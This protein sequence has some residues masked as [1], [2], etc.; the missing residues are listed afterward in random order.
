MQAR[1]RV[2][3]VATDGARELLL[4]ALFDER[5]MLA[6]QV[7]G[8]RERLEAV[9]NRLDPAGAAKR[10][11][12]KVAREIVANGIA[13][14]PDVLPVEQCDDYRARLE[15]ELAR[16]PD[17]WPHEDDRV[18]QKV[19]GS[20]YRDLD[21]YA[22]MAACPRIVVNRRMNPHGDWGMLDVF[23]VD[24][25]VPELGELAGQPHLL[26]TF[27]H[28]AGA[29]VILESVHLYLNDSVTQTRGL[30]ADSYS[31]EFKAFWYLTDVP[32]PSFGPHIYVRGSHR[33]GWQRFV[34]QRLSEERGIAPTD[35]FV[36]D[37]EQLQVVL[38]RRGSLVLSDQ[39]GAHRGMPQVQGRRRLVLVACYTRASTA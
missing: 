22:A 12:S 37:P 30:H 31:P 7:E 15:A 14:V 35:V 13:V 11:G 24:R 1:D 34:N 29:S 28:V 38:G 3:T 39:R 21:D 32:D 2:G 20:G 10:T 27:S 23:H 17:R 6:S 36:Y 25:W 18:I 8:L 9:E 4:E 19:Q 5:D 26:D 16:L 33:P